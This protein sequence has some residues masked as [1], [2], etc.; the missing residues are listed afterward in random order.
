METR[1]HR[2]AC[3]AYRLQAASTGAGVPERVTGKE[4]AEGK[5]WIREA[6]RDAPVAA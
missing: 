6:A 1:A 2:L 3:L 4:S 5:G